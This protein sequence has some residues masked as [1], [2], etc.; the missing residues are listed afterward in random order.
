MVGDV[1]NMRDG[2]YV[3]VNK[4]G[5]LEQLPRISQWRV[6]WVYILQ[7][8]GRLVHLQ[9]VREYFIRHASRRKIW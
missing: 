4:Q 1:V 9:N 7:R 3:Q 8:T 6:L 5:T 2:Y